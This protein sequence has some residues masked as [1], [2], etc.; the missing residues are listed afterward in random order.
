M[1]NYSN[2]DEEYNDKRYI[3]TEEKRTEYFQGG[4][5]QSFQCPR[6]GSWNTMQS[7]A[8]DWCKSCDYEEGYW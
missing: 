5:A 4:Q 7:A 1:E 3:S 2:Y 8:A 6:C